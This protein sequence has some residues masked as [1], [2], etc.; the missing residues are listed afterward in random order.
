MNNVAI[1]IRH[2]EARALVL[3]NIYVVIFYFF[4]CSLQESTQEYSK[5]FVDFF[6]LLRI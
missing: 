6:K 4:I 2:V 1:I 3:V 5:I